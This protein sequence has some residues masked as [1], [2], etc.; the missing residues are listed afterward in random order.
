M[1]TQNPTLKQTT[2][3]QTLADWQATDAKIRASLAPAGILPLPELANQTGLEALNHIISGKYPQ[4]PFGETL[5]YILIHA[6]YGQV[7]FQGRPSVRFYNPMGTVHGGWYC[8][9]LDSAL[10]CAV[11][12]TLPVGKAYTTLEIKVNMIKALTDK[13]PLVRA[14][15]NVVHVGKSTATAEAKLIGADGTLYAHATTTCFIF[16]VK[17]DNK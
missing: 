2:H 8:T 3:T 14:I 9:L 6:E 10:G 16:N 11:H 5:D 7:T 1:T 4:V 12:T 13:V 15:A 17:N